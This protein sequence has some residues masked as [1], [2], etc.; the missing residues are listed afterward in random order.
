MP[1][2]AS[3]CVHVEDIAASTFDIWDLL[4]EISTCH[5]CHTLPQARRGQKW[6]RDRGPGLILQCSDG[7][8][9]F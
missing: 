4:Q 6:N 3:R 2:S 7:F 1:M 9:F 5:Y 8:W